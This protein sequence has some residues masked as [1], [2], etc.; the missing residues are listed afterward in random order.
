[1]L[2]RD[3][4]A[5][6]DLGDRA[7]Y[8]LP[9]DDD[10]TLQQWLAELQAEADEIDTAVDAVLTSV[11][12]GEASGRALDEIGRDFGTLG[13]RRGRSD[14]QYRSFLRGLVAAFD[15]RGTVSG[16]ETAIA[17]GVLATADDVSLIEDFDTQ[18]YE[19]VLEN[20][21]WSE[22]RSGT[23]REL[24]ELADPSVVELREPVHNKL[25]TATFELIPASVTTF[26]G[27]SLDPTT[28]VISGGPTTKESTAVGLSSTEL[29]ELSTDDWVLSTIKR[30]AATVL[31]TLGETERS[32]M[33]V[34]TSAELR[35]IGGNT[36]T[37]LMTRLGPARIDVTA[38]DSD[39]ETISNRG[40]SSN[41]LGPLS[42]AEHA[43]L[44]TQ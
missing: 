28:V 38:A 1:M 35:V 18:Q 5:D 33:Y 31:I 21:A 17:A 23:V 37:P 12:L 43:E 13:R 10:T 41:Q 40:L 39:A 15:G 8:P 29:R 19:V 14:P 11:Q 26:S 30:P 42:S 32:S 4:D 3:A 16:V 6:V 44:S 34:A 9:Q 27:T 22:H 20:E 25:S 36:I 2:E 7:P 24:A